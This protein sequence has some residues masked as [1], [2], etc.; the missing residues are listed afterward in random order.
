MTSV[1]L[2]ALARFGRKKDSALARLPGSDSHLEL[3]YLLRDATTFFHRRFERYGRVFKSRFVKPL[4]FLIGEEANKTVLVTR[5]AELAFG[6]GYAQTAVRHVFEGSIML[7]DGEAHDRTRDLLSPAVGT[8]AVRGGCEEVHALW[9]NAAERLRATGE[10]DT[11]TLVQRTTFDVAANALTGLALGPETERF[12]PYFEKLIDGVM[13]PLPYRIPFGRLDRALKARETLLEL[14]RPRVLL[15]RAQAPD[16][17]LGQLAHFRDASGQHLSPE[18]VIGHLL[19]L[20]W[21]GYDTT[22]SAG[23]WVLYELARR[24]D[25]QARIRDEIVPAVAK[26]FEV[27]ASQSELPF[28]NWFLLEAERMYPSALFFPRVAVQDFAYGDHVIPAGTFTAYSPYMSH[29]DPE[30]FD[31]PDVFEPDRW[32]P[33]HG[34]KR[35]RAGLL[36]GFGGGPRICLG[37]AF[38][39]MQ[40]RA[41]MH[42]ILSRYHIE[43][44]PT[45]SGGV[46]KLPVFH[47]QNAGLRFRAI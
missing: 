43:P 24:Q 17:L 19:L 26:N 2:S 14:M 21:A 32:N 23:S 45:R 33:V 40:L 25:W 31:H 46:L 37:K 38:A 42:A 5:R 4:V 35:A 6:L 15:A 3:A 30:S 10:S 1:T 29:R 22:A 18:D 11:Y 28:S 34:A 9:A 12:R 27:L 20:F 16:R 41:M 39:K 7:E 8:L 47:P 44:D 13:A 36:V